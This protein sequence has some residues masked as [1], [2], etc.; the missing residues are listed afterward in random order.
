MFF[1]TNGLKYLFD[2]HDIESRNKA[3][4]NFHLGPILQQLAQLI[5]AMIYINMLASIEQ[6]LCID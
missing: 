4:I 6:S 5:F 2:K 1:K 3:N